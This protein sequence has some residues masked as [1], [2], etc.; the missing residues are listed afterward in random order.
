MK[1]IR[2]AAPAFA[3]RHVDLTGLT[4]YRGVPLATG[5][6]VTPEELLKEDRLLDLR[7]AGCVALEDRAAGDTC[8]HAIA[9]TEA[10]NAAIRMLNAQGGGTLVVPRG[11]FRVYTVQL[12]S[13]VNLKLEEGSVLQAARTD[14][15]DEQ[16]MPF[17]QAED[18]YPDGTPGNYLRPVANL[19]AGLQDNGH[20]YFENSLFYAD[21]QTDI[22]VYG[23]GLI[24]GSQTDETGRIVPVLTGFDPPDPVMRADCPPRWHGNKGFALV[25]CR[26]LV[27]SGIRILNGGHFAII[28]E[29]SRDMLLEDLVVD[30]IRD[31][32]DIDCGGDCTVRRSVFNSLTD[33]AIVMK[34]SFGGGEYSPL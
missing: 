6:S 27:L 10:I 33:D 22:M 9:N 21:G 5:C 19:W 24:D 1:T 25:R 28:T 17:Q 7:A 31:A 32:L 2:T 3:P 20:T 23:S 29:D 26:R 15:W 34:A 11:T 14:V 30:T 16:G 8:T 13:R 18:H 12:L 4:S